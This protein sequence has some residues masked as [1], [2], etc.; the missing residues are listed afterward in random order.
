MDSIVQGINNLIDWLGGIPQWFLD[1]FKTAFL[2]LWDMLY[3]LVCFV[4]DELFKGIV[5]L[6]AMIPI[7]TGLFNANQYLAGAPADFLNMLVAIRIPE[8]FAIIV[9][10]LVIRFLLGLIPVIRVGG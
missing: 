10:A 2:T 3:D 5:A 7:P 4:V 8:A 1:L 9:A 6:L